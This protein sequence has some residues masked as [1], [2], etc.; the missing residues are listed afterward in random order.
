MC[1]RVCICVCV[2][3]CVCVCGCVCVCVCGCVCVC[4]RARVCVSVCAQARSRVCIGV[5]GYACVN[6]CMCACVLVEGAYPFV[7]QFVFVAFLQVVHPLLQFLQQL[8]HH[9]WTCAGHTATRFIL[10]GHIEHKETRTPAIIHLRASAY[11]QHT[12]NYALTCTHS[13]IITQQCTRGHT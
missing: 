10:K 9:S 12:H 4:A 8:L 6:M 5:S 13:H 3:V 2:C 1:M 7:L 11:T